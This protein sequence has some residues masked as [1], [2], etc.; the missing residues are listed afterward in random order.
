MS[1]VH[2][3]E[4]KPT[5]I[6]RATSYH[7]IDVDVRNYDQNNTSKRSSIASAY[8]QQSKR[9]LP[10]HFETNEHENEPEVK[11]ESA[12]TANLLMSSNSSLNFNESPETH[13]HR[14]PTPEIDDDELSKMS[15]R[16]R[17]KF[18]QQDR[19]GKDHH[20]HHHDHH[21][22]DHHHH[23]HDHHHHDHH[24]VKKH[25][26]LEQII[27]QEEE[28]HHLNESDHEIAHTEENHTHPKRHVKRN[29]SLLIQELTNR[30]H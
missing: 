22:H 7:T 11:L 10:T 16:D 6:D 30:D 15:V 14:A 3:V 27:D 13:L 17:M 2:E 18:F 20:H 29:I 25:H 8:S 21:H 28:E 24:H 19:S 4:E 23:H 5:R 12:E 26:E 9:T 1:K